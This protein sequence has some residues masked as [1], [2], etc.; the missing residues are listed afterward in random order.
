MST[1]AGPASFFEGLLPKSRSALSIA[2]AILNQPG[3]EGWM[4]VYIPPDEKTPCEIMTTTH[5]WTMSLTP[6]TFRPGGKR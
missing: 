5:G 3:M 4:M 1:Q 2:S 6:E